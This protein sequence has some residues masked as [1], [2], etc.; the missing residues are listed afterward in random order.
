MDS[1]S[2]A[3]APTQTNDNVPDSRVIS[4]HVS[5]FFTSFRQAQMRF[6]GHLPRERYLDCQILIK[7]PNLLMAHFPDETFPSQSLALQDKVFFFCVGYDEL[8]NIEAQVDK[9][10]GGRDLQLIVLTVKAYPQR[11]R[12]FRIDADVVLKYWP[13][14]G[15]APVPCGPESKR[16]N[17][18]AVGLRFETTR[19]LRQVEKVGLELHLGEFGVVVC[20]GRVVRIRV[21]ESGRLESV[22]I[23]F[24]EIK[25]EEQEKIIRF[26]LN[27]QRTQLR[28][29]VRVL[30]LWVS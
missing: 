25:A 1:R 10:L 29:K 8:F 9:I 14:E 27:E 23:D 30:D 24:D 4:S 2:P 12:F 17:L 26:C 20:V 15:K 11:R 21:V 13:L 19:F 7:A 22:A 28:K 6:Y 3:V 18:S 16:V 5:R